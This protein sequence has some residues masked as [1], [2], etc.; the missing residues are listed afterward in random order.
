MAECFCTPATYWEPGSICGS[1]E[2]RLEAEAREHE[3][4][5]RLP[6]FSGGSIP[7]CV[8]CPI[9]DWPCYLKTCVGDRRCERGERT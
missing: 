3:E 4:E 1:C 2:A 8:K 6:L 9:S 7:D 5:D